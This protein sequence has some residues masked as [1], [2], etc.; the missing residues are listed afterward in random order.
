MTD[1]TGGRLDAALAAADL[2]DL[3]GAPCPRRD[4][5][6][7]AAS[8]TLPPAQVEELLAHAAT[9]AACSTAWRLARELDAATAAGV[10]DSRRPAPARRARWI[11]GAAGLVAAAAIVVAVVGGGWREPPVARP[12]FR[13]PAGARITSRLADG[14]PLSRSGA[15]LRWNPLADGAHYRVVVTTT[16][17]APVWHSEWIAATEAEVPASA[18]GALPPGARIAWRVEARVPDGRRVASAAFLQVVP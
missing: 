2:D 8:G 11:A 17:L 4:A 9:C 12:E 5:T 7:D 15:V 18:L 16:D 10:R 14:A 6:W 3:D 13:D 1:P